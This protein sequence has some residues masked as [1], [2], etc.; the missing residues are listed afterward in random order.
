V[1][2]R[3]CLLGALDH[4]RRDLHS[5]KLSYLTEDRA[6]STITL[7]HIY[8]SITFGTLENYKNEF[9]RFE[10]ACFNCG[11]NAIIGRPGLAKFMT[12]P[13][14]PYMILKMPGP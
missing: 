1:I 12:I 13:H 8:L 9:L 5:I 7:G 6:A 14:Y 10:V 11:Y 2:A 4:Q 3:N